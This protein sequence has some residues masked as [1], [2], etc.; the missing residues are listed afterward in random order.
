M[1]TCVF[2]CLPPIV[3]SGEQSGTAVPALAWQSRTFPSLKQQ[4]VLIWHAGSHMADL[5]AAPIG[6]ISLCASTES[7]A[8][9]HKTSAYLFYDTH[10]HPPPPRRHPQ[11]VS[12]NMHPHSD[13]YTNTELVKIWRRLSSFLQTGS[14]WFLLL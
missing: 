8:C 6:S 3:C 5:M 13:I 10:S 4:T 9:T 12:C 1:S 11:R 2:P 7:G 14:W